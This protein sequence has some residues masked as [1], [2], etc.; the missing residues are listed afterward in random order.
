MVIYVETEEE[1]RRRRRGSK[2]GEG[3]YLPPSV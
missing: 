1:R 2:T 3:Q